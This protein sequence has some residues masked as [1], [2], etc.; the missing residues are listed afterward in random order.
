MTT[1]VGITALDSGVWAIDPVHSSIGF[2]VRHLVVSKVRGTFEDFT[3]TI[4]V[5]PDGTPSVTAE[6]TVGSV[7]TGNEQRDAHIKSAEFFDT[8]QHPTARSHPRAPRAAAT[9]TLCPVTS[10]SRALRGR[11]HC[12]SCSMVSIPVPDRVRW[13]DSKRRSCSTA[14][15]LGSTLTCR[16]RPAVLSS[17][18][19]WPSAWR[20]RRSSKIDYHLQ[21]YRARPSV[22]QRAVRAAGCAAN[23]SRPGCSCRSTAVTCAGFGRHIRKVGRQLA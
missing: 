16:Y 10:H 15:T 18:T 11:S 22:A 17:E 6:I 19:K 1:S 3:G 9:T 20:S 2:A 13:P 21:P 14:K 8:E 5:A 23:N 7:H 4:T 12:P